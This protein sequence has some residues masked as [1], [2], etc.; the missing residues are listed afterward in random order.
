MRQSPSRSRSRP[1]TGNLETEI[2]LDTLE[3]QC[4]GLRFC[5]NEQ[6]KDFL[7]S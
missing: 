7:S 5:H 6:K 2:T 1:M 4:F 3:E